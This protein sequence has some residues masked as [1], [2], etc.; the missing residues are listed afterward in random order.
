LAPLPQSVCGVNVE[1]VRTQLVPLHV[2]DPFVGTG[3]ATHEVVPHELVDELLEH[4]PLHECV[5]GGQA[6]PPL[7]QAIPPVQT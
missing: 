1:Q 4:V 5:P 6:Q 7:W 2:A 3:H